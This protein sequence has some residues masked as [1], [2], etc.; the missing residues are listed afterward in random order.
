MR[1][2]T[3]DTTVTGSEGARADIRQMSRTHSDAQA[4]V[5]W[6]PMNRVVATVRRSAGDKQF[7]TNGIKCTDTNRRALSHTPNPS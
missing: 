2:R 4:P 7:R 1:M 5:K 6:S 3:L